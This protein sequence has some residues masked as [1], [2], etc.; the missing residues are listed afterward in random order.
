MKVNFEDFRSITILVDTEKNIVIFPISWS[1]VPH[2]LPDGSIDDGGYFE[3]YYPIEL[4]YP[5]TKEALAEKIQYGIELWNVHPCYLREKHGNVTFEAKYKGIKSFRKAVKGFL[6]MSLGWNDISGKYV[7]LFV[8]WKSA[9]AYIGI[10]DTKLEDDADWLDFAEVVMKYVNMD[11][12]TL[13]SFKISK[14]SIN[15]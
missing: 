5:Y 12:T 13:N 4:K 8:P 1:D 10:D 11:V 15:W 6:Y 2:E 9:Y 14:R 7:S 3:A